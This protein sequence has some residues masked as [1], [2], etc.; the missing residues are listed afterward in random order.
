MGVN[1]PTEVSYY[2]KVLSFLF[3]SFPSPLSLF[4][5][6]FPSLFLFLFSYSLLK[7]V[8]KSKSSEPRISLDQGADKYSHKKDG[9]FNPRGLQ[10][11]GGMAFETKVFFYSF[12]LFFFSFFFSFFSL[13]F[14]FFLLFSLLFSSSLLSLFVTKIF[15]FF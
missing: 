1:V 13:F 3:L 14:S 5:L 7:K 2:Y 11:T 4:L 8:E 9:V 10:I 12:F 15:P 6:P